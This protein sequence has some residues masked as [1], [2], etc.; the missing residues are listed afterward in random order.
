MLNAFRHQ[1]DT[2][3]LAREI[4]SDLANFPLSQVRS[5]YHVGNSIRKDARMSTIIE[6]AREVSSKA[7]AVQKVHFDSAEDLKQAILAELWD[8]E[9]P[10]EVADRMREVLFRAMSKITKRENRHCKRHKTN[11]DFGWSHSRTPNDNP[12]DL[13]SLGIVVTS[14][15]ERQVALT[16][17]GRHPQFADFADLAT[18]ELYCSQGEAYK[19]R[20]RFFK[21]IREH[22]S[23][24]A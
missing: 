23:K 15:F 22:H 18:S 4:L 21:R 14:D 17:A 16:E 1:Q 20:S 3:T 12:P 8:T 5:L 24:T 7:L 19:R 2:R 6:L 11:G 10:Q 13:E 9:L